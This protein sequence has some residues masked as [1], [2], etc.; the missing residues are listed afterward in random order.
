MVRA[1]WTSVSDN[2]LD[3]VIE[4]VGIHKEVRKPR[5]IPRQIE[6]VKDVF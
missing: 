4:N 1:R 3:K 5:L 6:H 2:K